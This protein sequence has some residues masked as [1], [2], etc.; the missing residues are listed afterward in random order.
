VCF[1]RDLI[2]RQA[3]AKRGVH[4]AVASFQDVIVK[5]S[6]FYYYIPQINIEVSR[7]SINIFLNHD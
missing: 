7:F 3:M 6:R 4:G 1:G 2:M 5:V